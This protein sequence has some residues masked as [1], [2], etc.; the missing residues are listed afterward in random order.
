MHV[1]R[2][3]WAQRTTHR[4]SERDRAHYRPVGTPMEE[5]RDRRKQHGR[6]DSHAEAEDHREQVRHPQL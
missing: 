2:E 3:P 1:T 5:V 6:Q 4:E